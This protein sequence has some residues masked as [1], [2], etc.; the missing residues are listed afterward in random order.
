MKVLTAMDGY[1]VDAE[2][3][4]KN[5]DSLTSVQVKFSEVWAYSHLSPNSLKRLKIAMTRT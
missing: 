1:D 5:L 3:G 2:T 4:D